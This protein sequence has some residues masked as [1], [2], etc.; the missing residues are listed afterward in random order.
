VN[1]APTHSNVLTVKGI[2]K[3]ILTNAHSGG[4]ASTENGIRRNTL[5]SVTTGSNQFALRKATS[6]KYNF[7][8]LQNLISKRPEKPSY[9]QYHPRDTVT[10]RHDLNPRTTMVYY[11]QSSQYFK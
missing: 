5:K 10:L 3:P 7:E 1:R 4:I 11:L 2:I 9:H 6:R 8:E